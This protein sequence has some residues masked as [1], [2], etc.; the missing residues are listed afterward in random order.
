YS[1]A[2]RRGGR[3]FAHIP[4]PRAG[5]APPARP[6]VGDL[7]GAAF[8]ATDGDPRT[9]WTAP[10]DSVRA[11]TGPKPTLTLELPEPALVTGL[12]LTPP[13]GG[14]PA[15]PTAVVVNLGDGPQ[16]RELEPGDPGT[17]RRISLHPTVTDRIEL[18]LQSWRPVLDQTALGFVLSQP[19]GLAEVEVLGPGYPAPAPLDREITVPCALG[20]TITVDGQIRH[21]SV[22][23]TAD[24][25]RSGAP[26]AAR[27][28]ADDAAPQTDSDALGLASGRAEVT[29]GPTDL[30][31]VDRLRLDRTDFTAATP[32]DQGTRV[33]V[34]PLSTNVGWQ[35]KTADGRALEPVV[36]DGWQQAWLVPADARGPVTVS[37]P[38]DR[39][40]RLGIFGGL[41]LLFPLFF[42]ALP[43]R[44]RT[45]KK[46]A[47]EGDIAPE[48]AAS[49]DS[50]VPDTTPNTGAATKTGADE[51]HIPRDIAATPKAPA[52]EPDS[53]PRTWGTRWLGALGLA[54]AATVIAGPVGTLLTAG[55]L[56]A[57]RFRP[58]YAAR[59]L[60]VVAGVGTVLSAAVL[61]TGPWRSGDGYLGGSLWAQLPALL[62]VVAV[63]VAALPP[64]RRK[65]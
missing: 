45:S 9:S 38:I 10:E 34:L 3:R 22:T 15:T 46:A 64:A 13:L 17:P 40:Y 5:G 49:P 57:I 39:W 35:A 1:A 19:P 47:A 37:F 20:P 33:L 60:V 30:F 2:P 23:A 65:N 42:L 27:V 26:V 11:L 36:V 28:C 18:S 61:S 29:V 54:A 24:E 62:A 25:L 41:L 59:A 16:V 6:H 56:A 53:A 48:N 7:R 55:T 14:L 52:D 8:A 43:R 4:P 21:T 50:E 12:D 32:A 31:F 63:G 58:R 51:P 44:T